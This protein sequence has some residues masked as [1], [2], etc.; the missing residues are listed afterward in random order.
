M[1]LSKVAL[2]ITT[3]AGKAPAL[4]KL[5]DTLLDGIEARPGVMAYL[6]AKFP[7]VV[8]YEKEA[9]EAINFLLALEGA[10]PA[11]AGEALTTLHAME[12]AAAAPPV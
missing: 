6:N 8:K 7:N 4:L 9:H 2:F 10:D 3:L 12:A 11:Q 1:D 5:L